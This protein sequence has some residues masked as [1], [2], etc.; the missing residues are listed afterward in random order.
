MSERIE[1]IK[2]D[3]EETALKLLNGESVTSASGEPITMGAEDF[4]LVPDDAASLIDVE[5]AVAA[6]EE[7]ISN[8]YLDIVKDGSHIKVN[9]DYITIGSG[10]GPVELQ[11]SSISLN[12]PYS[13][14][15]LTSLPTLTNTMYDYVISA[16]TDETGD[17]TLG[18]REWASNKFADYM[19]LTNEQTVTGTKTFDTTILLPNAPTTPEEWTNT[20]TYIQRVTGKGEQEVVNGSSAEINEIKGSTVRCENLFDKEDITV[21]NNVDFSN[22]HDVSVSDDKNVIIATGNTSA[23]NQEYANSK[24]WVAPTSYCSRTYNKGISF[25]TGEKITI[26][27]DITLIEQGDRSAAVACY[28][29]VVEAGA[30]TITGNTGKAISTK[31]TRYTWTFTMT[32]DNTRAYPVFCINSNRVRIENIMISKNGVTEYQPYFTDLKHS[33]FK[34]VKSTGRNLVD[35]SKM[36]NEHFTIDENGICTMTRTSKDGRFSA[37][38]TFPEP[39]PAGKYTISCDFVSYTGTYSFWLQISYTGGQNGFN[40]GQTKKTIT[41]T[42]PVKSIEFYAD[43]QNEIG[44]Y[45]QFKNFMLNA[46]STAQPFEPYVEDTYKLPQTLE[47]MKYDSFNPQTGEITRQTGTITFTGTENFGALGVEWS[48]E[49][50]TPTATDGINILCVCNHY[51]AKPREILYQESTEGVAVNSGYVRFKDPNYTTKEEFKAHLAQLYN[52]GTPVIVSYKLAVPTIEKIEN[53]PTSYTAYN[54]GTETVLAGDIDNS[55]YG[56]IPTITTTY[57]IHENPTEAANKAY[58]NNGLAK[59]LDKTGGT[60]TGNLIVE[61]GTTTT[62]P[63]LVVKNNEH[64]FG[65]ALEEDTYKLGTG[66]VEDGVFAFDEGEGRPVALR[67]NSENFKNEVIPIWNSEG[68]YFE[69]SGKTIDDIPQITVDGVAAKTLKIYVSADGYLCIDTE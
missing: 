10:I 29:Y 7:K 37:V 66:K 49:T 61:N 62:L 34:G 53:V 47:L 43:G 55:E 41:F 65:L 18:T 22:C 36:V 50:P 67:D 20:D 26:S 52:A 28:W 54:Q 3:S 64:T 32:A 45:Y 27:A 40:V 9:K 33:Y 14:I 5:E 69:S 57:K 16:P 38:F 12:S 19:D 63:A 25:K 13:K 56:A 21:T 15:N 60:I 11:G 48:M 46:G 30:G 59:K 51:T 1:F 35:V 44:T 39:L 42:Q 23:A 58:V 6:L 24:G 2:T 8:N 31:K 17:L 68:N 4:V